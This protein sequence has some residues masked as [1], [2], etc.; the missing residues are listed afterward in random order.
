[1]DVFHLKRQIFK[2]REILKLLNVSWDTPFCSIPLYSA[3]PL[4]AR[5]WTAAEEGQSWRISAFM[6]H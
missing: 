4:K 6:Q 3:S 5:T 1:M 2:L